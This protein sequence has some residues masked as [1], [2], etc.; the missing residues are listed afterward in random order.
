MILKTSV[1]LCVLH[2]FH[3]SLSIDC[4]IV[5]ANVFFMISVL[6]HL[7]LSRKIMK[8]LEKEFSPG[9]AF[10]LTPDRPSV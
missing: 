6:H 7:S 10:S 1:A 5:C 8:Y 9:C 3:P 4:S 2:I